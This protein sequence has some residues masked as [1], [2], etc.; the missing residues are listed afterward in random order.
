MPRRRATSET[1]SPAARQLAS[2]FPLEDFARA[3][4]KPTA[5]ASDE[6]TPRKVIPLDTAA[7]TS[8]AAPRPY[9]EP[10]G[11]GSTANPYGE[12]KKQFILNAETAER[13]EE[14]LSTLKHALGYSVNRSEFLRILL[15]ALEEPVIRRFL[16]ELDGLG[17]VK[18]RPYKKD[19][20]R[21]NQKLERTLAQALRRCMKP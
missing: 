11:Q 1:H 21:E 10:L 7:D 20:Q 5:P 13:L 2:S 12:W 3:I 17:V 19:N 16:T 4:G 15:L 8:A 6:P 9:A 14:L 18:R